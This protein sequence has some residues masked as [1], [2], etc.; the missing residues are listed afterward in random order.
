VQVVQVRAGAAAE[1][2]AG[3]QRQLD[4]TMGQRVRVAAWQGGR[5]LVPSRAAHDSVR[6]G[7]KRR[8]R[9]TPAATEDRW[10]T[11]YRM[12]R[13]PA[14]PRSLSLYRHAPCRTSAG[15]HCCRASR[16]CSVSDAPK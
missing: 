11:V 13:L 10:H 12:S 2:H 5:T 8:G 6:E 3:A 9:A 16:L 15:C 1:G 14:R 4:C 7:T